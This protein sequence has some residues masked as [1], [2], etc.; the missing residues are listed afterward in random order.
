MQSNNNKNDELISFVSARLVQDEAIDDSNVV[1]VQ[2]ATAV[3]SS[4]QNLSFYDSAIPV[5]ARNV[6]TVPQT[7]S[8]TNQQQQV[9]TTSRDGQII[10]TPLPPGRSDN[11]PVARAYR[12]PVVT[13]QKRTLPPRVQVF[14]ER[15]RKQQ[16]AAAVMGGIVGGIFLGPLGA[17]FGG[18]V[19][20][21][22]TK[23]IGRRRQAQIEKR[24][25]AEEN[26]RIESS[27][28]ENIPT[29]VFA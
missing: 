28:G 21:G 18:L 15:R 29:A 22:T 3:P 14:K 26:T 17:V 9:T 11:L 24:I 1:K 4:A 13:P 23:S 2:P 19:A 6:T 7:D 16:A 12:D 25:A 20:H 8:S 27:T 5:S 10:V